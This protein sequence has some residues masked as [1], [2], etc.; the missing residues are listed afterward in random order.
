MRLV[1]DSTWEL[2]SRCAL[3]QTTS[4]LHSF[5]AEAVLHTL[6]GLRDTRSPALKLLGMT[7]RQ[8]HSAALNEG[9][10]ERLTRT[11]VLPHKLAPRVLLISPAQLPWL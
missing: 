3:F 9:N 6:E 11:D 8:M 10:R 7:K 5:T 1:S 2:F 4:L